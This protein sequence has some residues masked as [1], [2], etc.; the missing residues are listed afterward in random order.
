MTDTMTKPNTGKNPAPNPS[1]VKDSSETCLVA[2]GT[3]IEGKFTSNENVRLDGT[4]KGEI[5]CSKRL[6]MGPSGRIEG[7]I[8]TEDAIIMGIFEGEMFANGTLHLKETA[9]V[10]GVIQAKLIIVEEG[11][12]YIGDCKIGKSE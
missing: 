2:S 10:K 12:Q 1:S 9:I 3:S 5:K 11:A 7:K 8:V 4:V 6:V